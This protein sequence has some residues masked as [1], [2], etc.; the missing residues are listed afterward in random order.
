[1][2]KPLKP[3]FEIQKKRIGGGGDSDGGAKN[4]EPE[5]FKPE[6]IVYI[7]IDEEITHVFDKI[8]RLPVKNIAIVIPR[9]AIVLQSIINLKILK[10]KFD[11][12]GKKILIITTDPSGLQLCE[13]AGISAIE[14]LYENKPDESEVKAPLPTRT[15]RPIRTAHGEKMSIAEVINKDKKSLLTSVSDKIKEYL[16]KKKK[17]AG[18]TRLV[19]ITPNKQALFTLIL[20]SVLLLLAIAYIALPGAT[21]YIT[22]RS[23]VI[24]ASFNISFLDFE[25]NRDLLENTYANNL[26]AATFPINPPL[27][28]RKITHNSTGKIFKGSN[29]RGIVT[30]VNLSANPWDLVVKT[31]FQTEEGLIFRLINSVR[32]PGAKGNLPGTLPAEVVADEFD[33]DGQTI[34]DR[35]NIPASKFSLPGIKNEENKRK[36]YAESKVPMTGGSTLVTKN[37]TKNDIDAAINK[38]KILIVKE[39]ANDLKKY[40]EEQN[41]IK[42]T[43]LSILDDK[44]VIKVSE[45][46]IASAG[47][48]PGKEAEQFELTVTY[49]VKGLAFDRQQ[50]NN[51]LK[52][53]LSNR[54]DPDKRITKINEN[55]LSY[56]FLDSDENAGKV[57]L[58]VTIRAIQ[59]YELDPE[60]ENGR[61]FLKKIADHILGLRVKDA[62]NYLQQQ[63]DEI[64]KVEITTWPVWAPTIPN[65]TD[66]IKFVIKEE[67][68]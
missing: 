45:P 67:T 57:R 23:S 18:Q 5:V 66:N 25:R 26:S 8:K 22:P 49:S 21:I 51:M 29:A 19:L 34:G 11:E 36:L 7:E 52:E 24:D 61:R 1:M 17:D 44:H 38:A 33:S 31:R 63:T 6:K 15:E 68:E 10:K 3:R 32:V 16:K 56:R 4:A 30:I 62:I 35:G 9:R 37:I 41:L 40:I 39:A 42:K 46:Q 20:V 27:F 13:K 53:R 65:I 47:D 59:A 55:D 48:L 14:R 58:T 54:V 64:A 43:S 2:D 60:K 12:T 28:T 50:L